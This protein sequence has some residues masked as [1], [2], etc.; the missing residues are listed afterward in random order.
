MSVAEFVY[1]VL[2]RPIWIKKIVNKAILL[3]LP[4]FVRVGEAV[5][6]INPRDPVV[7]GALAFRVYERDEISLIG[8]ICEPGQIVIDV[9]A[10]VGLYTALSGIAVGPTGKVFSFE[11]DSEC[12][13]FLRETVRINNLKNVHLVNAAVSTSA[14]KA[15]LH[16]SSQNRGDNRLYDCQESDGSVEVDTL[17]LDDYLDSVRITKVDVI[18]IDVQGY[19]GHIIGSLERTIARSP[20]LKMLIEFFPSGLSAAGTDPL[21]LLEKLRAWG[22]AMY[23]IQ[24]SNRFSPISDIDRFVGGLRG[25]AY[26]NILLL[27]PSSNFNVWGSG[28]P[29]SVTVTKSPGAMDSVVRVPV[30]SVGQPSEVLARIAPELT[31]VIPTYNERENLP[32][33]VDSIRQ[34]LPDYDWEIMVVDDDSPDGTS[35]VA[36]SIG[37]QDRR[38]RC[39]RRVGRRG[40]SGAFLEGALASQAR[41][42]AVIDADTQHDE[43]LLLAM[44]ERIRQNDIDLVVASRYTEGGSSACFSSWR[45]RASRWAANLVRKL[46]KVKLSDPMSGYFMVR[47]DIVEEAAP[48]LSP[49]GF[50]ILL[51]IVS[52]LHDRIRVAEIPFTFRKRLYGESKLDARVAI[53]FAS[54]VIDKLTSNMVSARFLLFCLVGLTGLILHLFLLREGLAVGIG[55]EIAQI[56]S[57]VIVIAQN[58]TVNNAITYRDQQLKG[59]RFIMGL[60]R[61]ELIC[62]ISI[63]ANVGVASLVYG[64]RGSW[65]VAGM[66][67]AIMSVAWNYI[68]SAAFVWRQR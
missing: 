61:F 63:I 4:R 28:M 33:L 34:L 59:L 42:I 67:G 9:G 15:V 47:R 1:T 35:T 49:H 64:D 27:G 37:K 13:G 16:T 43:S 3:L 40:L 24:R 29:R 25:R 19:E 10:N 39:I 20:Y 46:L 32:V 54:L 62:S 68:M 36:R 26:A 57:A 21:L 5:I 2:F 14:G 65:W 11:P 6:S 58:F 45:A 7:S 66:A 48:V 8:R 52:S 22:L 56:L 17:C 18:K 23:E 60:V 53:D 12:F 51:D 31:I 50:K 30:L 38:V 44:L 55:F 41:Y